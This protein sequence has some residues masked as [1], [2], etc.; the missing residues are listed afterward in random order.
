MVRIQI[1]EEWHPGWWL[2]FFVAPFFLHPKS[3]AI[4]WQSNPPIPFAHGLPWTWHFRGKT[5]REAIGH[6][7][8]I[9]A[10][11]DTISL[12]T[13]LRHIYIY[14]SI[15][16][17]KHVSGNLC[18]LACIYI[19]RNFMYIHFHKHTPKNVYLRLKLVVS[20]NKKIKNS[21]ASPQKKRTVCFLKKYSINTNSPRRNE[22]PQSF[23]GNKFLSKNVL[24]VL[25]VLHQEGNGK[26]CVPNHKVLL[27]Q[28]A[29]FFGSAT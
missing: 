10:H 8:S 19:Y 3:A 17:V 13:K 15:Y 14:M 4:S 24:E 2:I 23:P 26:L 22:T 7:G 1:V 9:Y 16:P 25:E 5:L 12:L 28:K 27:N 20:K 18:P 11:V 6:W 29:T 21:P